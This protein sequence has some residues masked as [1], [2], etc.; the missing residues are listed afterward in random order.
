MSA[1][2]PEMGSVREGFWRRMRLQLAVGAAALAVIALVV[3][4]VLFGDNTPPPRQ[5]RDLTIVKIMPPPPP[6]P[7]PPQPPPPQ[8]PKMIE[9]PKMVEPEV[10]PDKP[11]DK[12]LDKPKDD[13]KDDTPPAGPLSLDAKAEG[14]GDLFGLGGNP[15]GRG[16]LGGGGGGGGSRWGWYASLVQNALQTALRANSII[17]NSVMKVEVRLWADKS[18]RIE[19]I[20]LASSTGDKDLDAA[21]RDVLP[22]VSLG[23]P[24]PQ[25]MPM[26]I[27][28]QIILRR[29]N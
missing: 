13:A 19:R 27:D 4:L 7:P 1:A 29:P 28:T 5:V 23:E 20:Q 26:P 25:D 14:P 2:A 22:G 9:Q 16:F 8:Q 21:L 18:G 15:G 3:R 10:K 12:P 24:P 6:P 17:R 11:D